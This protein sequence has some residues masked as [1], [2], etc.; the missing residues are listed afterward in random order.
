MAEIT[1]S[2]VKDAL[3]AF[4]NRDSKLARSVCEKMNG[5]WVK[6]S[7]LPRASYL[8]DGGSKDD[9]KVRPPDD[10]LPLP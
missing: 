8:Y 3:G 5:G 6:R 2:M 7:G 1:Q 4:V 10:R 9:P